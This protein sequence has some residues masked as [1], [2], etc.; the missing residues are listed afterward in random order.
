MRL[1]EVLKTTRPKNPADITRYLQAL[2][3]QSIFALLSVLETVEL[4]EN[5]VL[6]GD[7]LAQYAKEMP[8][9]FVQRLESDRP[10]T[11]RDMVYILEKSQHPDR[12]KMFGQVLKGR[13]LVVKLEVMN[14]IARGRTGE[15]RKL[16]ADALADPIS[17]VRVLAARLLPEFDREKAYT[18]LVRMVRDAGFDKKTSEEK[19]AIYQAIGSTGLPGAISMM[20]QLLAVKPNMLNK[21][22]V[23][24]D[25]L[26]AIQGLA[27]A[28]SIQS[29]KVLQGVVEDKSQPLEV[30]TAAR[31]V[32]YQTK[33]A[34]F[35][36]SALAEEA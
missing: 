23:L 11:V 19:M 3:S 12:I 30:L 27:G 18:D 2:D 25:K 5:R 28:G 13:N 34:L 33:K 36:D 29:Y 32:M 21:K 8:E 20:T 17:Q 7:V 35:G 24:D 1:G 16:I 9:P 10:Q 26:L 14:I 22:R 6:L 15:A 31:K 4:P